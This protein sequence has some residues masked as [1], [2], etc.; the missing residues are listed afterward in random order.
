MLTLEERVRKATDARKAHARR[1]RFQHYLAE[2]RGAGLVVEVQTTRFNEPIVHPD[3]T[4]E[5]VER[6]VRG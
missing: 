3:Y 2:M 1:R 4:V 6:A 5:A